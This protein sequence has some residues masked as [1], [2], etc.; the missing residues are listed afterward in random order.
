MKLRILSDLHSEFFASRQH[1]IPAIL[2]L[3]FP[4]LPEDKNTILVLAGDIGS[5][6]KPKCLLAVLD[7]LAPRFKFVLYTPGNH[8][9][10][11]SNLQD[12]VVKIHNLIKHHKNVIF[13]NFEKIPSEYLG[14]SRSFTIW[15][16][17]LWTGYR[18]GNPLVMLDA[19][20]GMN[21][22]K[23]IGSLYPDPQNL[24]KKATPEEILEVHRFMFN[25]LDEGV[26]EG[27]VIITH[28]APSERSVSLEYLHDKLNDAYFTNLDDWILER[29]PS[30]MIH[31]HM[32]A[33]VDYMIGDTRVFSNPLGILGHDPNKAFKPTY[34]IEI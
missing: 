26:Q 2:D 33:S 5:L 7:H 12:Y 21:D 20:A 22:F 6:H 23:H 30:L 18:S 28:H 9:P 14:E 8:E 11:G 15:L 32:H 31:G 13:D 1:K 3:Y 10:Y 24:N 27:D 29:K 34:V 17:T 19:L 25:L 4:P 16:T